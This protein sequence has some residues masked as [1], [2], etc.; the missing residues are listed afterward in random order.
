MG[1]TRLTEDQWQKAPWEFKV[2]VG[3]SGR[4]FTI[5]RF[6]YNDQISQAGFED[7]WNVGGTL[8]Y[9]TDAEFI[10]IVSTSAADT[11]LGTG[12]QSVRL[13]GVDFEYK[14]LLETVPLDGLTPVQTQNKFLR[15][16]T[17]RVDDVG[18]GL[19][20][21]GEIDAT[22]NLSATIQCRIEVDL[23]ASSGTFITIPDGFFGL[24]TAVR[25][26]TEGAD[27]A[28]ID[29]Q[30]RQE[31]KGFIVGYRTSLTAG[32]TTELDFMRFQAPV[33]A[34][35]HTDIKVRGIYDAGGATRVMSAGISL[36]L[37]DQREINT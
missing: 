11:E 24:I 7:V 26:S 14:R 13:M 5:L 32:G 30:T 9:L 27:P 25:A 3:F 17:M 16:E 33:L 6:G 18:S 2:A 4:F 28:V 34:P 10:D 8:E 31:G 19:I 36:Y 23:G 1:Y 20:N 29:F 12:A 15:V 22:S 37:I 21:A 35:P